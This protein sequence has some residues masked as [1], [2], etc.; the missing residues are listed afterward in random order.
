MKNSNIYKSLRF[1]GAGA[2]LS[3]L[4]CL[5]GCGSPDAGAGNTETAKEG[6][7]NVSQQETPAQCN[8]DLGTCIQKSKN[9][10][11][12]LACN[13]PYATCLASGLT[14]P[15][16]TTTVNGLDACR[17]TLGTCSTAAKTPAAL[18]TCQVSAV[19]CAASALATP[20]AQTAAAAVSCV[21]AAA[22]CAG[23]ATSATDIAA[24]GQTFANC[25]EEAAA[26]VLPPD[27]VTVVTGVTTCTTTL[28]T[29]ITA[30]KTPDALNQC[31]SAEVSC[32][33]TTLGVPIPNPAAAITCA[34]SA[35]KCVTAAKS[36]ADVNACAA[37]LTSCVAKAAGPVVDCNLQFTQCFAKNPFN[38]F[39]CAD[40]ARK[41]QAGQ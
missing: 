14:P 7:G 25:A 10:F 28:G 30:A 5:P 20:I 13:G 27:V 41:C 9:I 26:A 33:G 39:M 34:E 4:V 32:I 11:D 6:V 23:K 17:T 35:A 21:D 3:Y 1:A 38:I 15:I 37:T 40:D 18:A 12:L 36:I 16:V 2:T 24:C 19:T 29:C 8:T 31:N 22:V